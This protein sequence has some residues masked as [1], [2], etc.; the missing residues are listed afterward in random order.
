M[1]R[2]IKFRGHRIDSK[3]WVYGDLLTRDIDTG[4]VYI[5]VMNPENLPPRY[6]DYLVDPATV[7]QF[8][9]LTDT[10]EADIY[11]GD[12]L[13][14]HNFYFDG[15]SEAENETKGVLQWQEMGLQLLGVT[16]WIA[17]YMGY[18]DGDPKAQ[19]ELV[20]LIPSRFMDVKDSE[21]ILLLNKWGLHEESF[22]IIGNI[23]EK[24]KA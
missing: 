3:E 13:H 16:G 21:N 1:N 20:E 8:T 12:I 17:E 2:V 6:N 22:L 9:G 14:V 7:G 15:R 11:E 10:N 23:H 24:P 19:T 5:R 18:E 4:N